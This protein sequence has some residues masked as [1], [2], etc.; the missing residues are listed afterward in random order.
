MKKLHFF[1]I[2]NMKKLQIDNHLLS[3]DIARVDKKVAH[4]TLKLTLK[5]VI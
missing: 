2:S 4:V 1:K 5:Y 3:M